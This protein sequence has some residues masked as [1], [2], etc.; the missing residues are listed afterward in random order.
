MNFT[1]IAAAALA[2]AALAGCSS[3]SATEPETTATPEATASAEATEEAVVTEGTYTITN[4]T[5]ETV[6]ELYLYQTGS[7]DKGTNYAEDGLA[8]GESVTVEVSVSED[9]AADYASTLEYTTE[10]GR[11]ENS[12]TTLHLEE[13]N[14]NLLDAEADGYTSAT[15]FSWGF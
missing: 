4:T 14:L 5:G 2:A 10:S 1:K 15:P 6:T 13:A 7:E 11:T 8:D 12:F 3:T 9:E